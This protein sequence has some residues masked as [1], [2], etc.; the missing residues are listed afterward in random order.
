[1]RT[2]SAVLLELNKTIETDYSFPEYRRPLVL[3]V[4]LFPGQ[5]RLHEADYFD[6]SDHPYQA[7]DNKK[8]IRTFMSTSGKRGLTVKIY[9]KTEQLKR[10][11][12]W[13]LAII[14]G[15]KSH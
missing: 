15:L 7:T 1:M 3:M 9:D 12:S 8:V 5:L 13:F 6:Q 11:I 10:E 14:C 2:Q 4:H